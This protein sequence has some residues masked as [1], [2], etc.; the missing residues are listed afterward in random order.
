MEAP[1]EPG[2]AHLSR[3][4]FVPRGPG[5]LGG[6]DV[7]TALG[8]ARTEAF[9]F[10]WPLGWGMWGAARRCFVLSPRVWPGLATCF[11]PKE[12]DKGDACHFHDRL[13]EVVTSGL[14]GLSS[15]PLACVL[16]GVGCQVG[17]EPIHGVRGTESCP[18]H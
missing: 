17:R 18:R 11:S 16:H 12:Y 4:Q 10:C 3:V 14:L 2:L 5:L 1:S 7:L 13:R 8:P 6:S 15:L 9:E